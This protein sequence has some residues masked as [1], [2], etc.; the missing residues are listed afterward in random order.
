MCALAGVA[1]S[2]KAADYKLDLE[3]PHHIRNMRADSR[4][5]IPDR[6]DLHVTGPAKW[7][8]KSHHL[9][10]EQLVPPCRLTNRTE[11]TNLVAVLGVHENQQ[12]ITNSSRLKGYT[13]HL[14]MYND[15]SR[16]LMHFRIFEPTELDTPWRAVVPQNDTGSVW[17]NDR[18]GGWLRARLDPATNGP[19]PI[20]LEPKGR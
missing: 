2:A 14:L 15:D 10:I 20:P 4:F 11:I 3:G 9:Y 13:C 7:I 5:H 16:S 12:R 8:D 19:V 6:V 18:I 1:A 17:F